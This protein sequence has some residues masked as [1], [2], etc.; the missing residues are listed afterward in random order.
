M[1]MRS[2]PP[3]SAHL[4]DRPV[5]APAPMIGR[6]AATWERRRVRMVSRV[7]GADMTASGCG[8][9]SIVPE[10]DGTVRVMGEGGT[11]HRVTEDT[12]GRHTEKTANRPK[13]GG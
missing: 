3:A 4:A 5:P 13:A 7:G 11:N 2:T 10:R 9:P 1:M 12:E 8:V 6:P